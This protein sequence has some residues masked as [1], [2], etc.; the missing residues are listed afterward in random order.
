MMEKVEGD[1][2]VNMNFKNAQDHV[3]G[4]EENNYNRGK[5]PSH[6]SSPSIV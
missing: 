1:L 4:A 3:P 6:I 2:N 5:E